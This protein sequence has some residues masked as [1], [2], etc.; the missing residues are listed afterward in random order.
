MGVI[1]SVGIF[2]GGSVRSSAADEAAFYKSDCGQG[3]GEY[4]RDECDEGGEV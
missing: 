3:Y 1:A 2:L 4:E